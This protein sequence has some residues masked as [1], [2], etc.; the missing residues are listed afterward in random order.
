MSEKGL[1][2]MIVLIGWA[3]RLAPFALV[4]LGILIAWICRHLKLGW[5]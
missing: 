4:L 1:Y 3:R 2:R 5:S